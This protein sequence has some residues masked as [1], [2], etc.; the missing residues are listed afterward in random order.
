MNNYE[1]RIQSLLDPGWQ[2]R[3]GVELLEHDQQRGQTLLS[4]TLDQAQLQ[5]ILNHIHDMGLKLI[6]VKMV[7][8]PE[9]SEE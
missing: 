9:L 3:F 4:S 7:E 1:I 2:Q 8:R 5:G 6:E